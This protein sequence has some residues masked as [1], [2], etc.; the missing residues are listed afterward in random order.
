MGKYPIQEKIMELYSKYD[1]DLTLDIAE[2]EFGRI[3]GI[4]ED[5]RRSDMLTD[6][7]MALLREWHKEGV[8]TRNFANRS[9]ACLAKAIYEKFG[10]EYVMLI[11][12]ANWP[13]NEPFLMC[14]DKNFEK[15]ILERSKAG[16]NDAKIFFAIYKYF[17]S[18]QELSK[19]S[20]FSDG[21]I[22]ENL[23][24]AND[25]FPAIEIENAI[26]GIKNLFN[27]PQKSGCFIATAAM[28]TPLAEEVLILSNFR[29]EFL[30]CKSWGRKLISFYYQVSPPLASLI[31]GKKPLCWLVQSII[32]HP[33][34]KL[35]KK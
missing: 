24:E 33:L 29:D 9:L 5:L 6:Q 18:I 10:K 35:I 34:V 21:D 31:T 7:D 17:C 12:N 30:S 16:S 13:L 1:P 14:G 11:P 26:A 27:K 4:V 8:G 19:G 23:Y 3:L 20:S 2:D 25:I 15:K 22:L 32:I 28:G